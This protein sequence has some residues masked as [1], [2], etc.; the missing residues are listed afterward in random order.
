MGTS[1]SISDVSG[2]PT[3]KVLDEKSKARLQKAVHEFESL[4]VSYMLKSMRATIS[5]EEGFGENFGG[6]MLEGMFDLE[7]SKQMSKNSNL[8]LGEKLYR[9]MTGEALP[10]AT[11]RSPGAAP[12]VEV[13][14]PAA[15]RPVV[16]V[17]APV[18]VPAK[19]NPVVPVPAVVQPRA[20]LPVVPAAAKKDTTVVDQRVRAL[21]PIIQEAAETHDIDPNLLKA[22]IASES[23]GRVRAR[24]SKNAKG[25]MQLIDSTAADMGVHNVWNPREN[26][27]GGA[28]YLQK[29]LD[30]F[31]GDMTKAVASY[32]AGPGAVEKHGGIPP[33]KETQ[34]YVTRVMEFLRHYE[35][36]ESSDNE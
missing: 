7:L 8:G 36:Q 28:K 30:R 29:L 16:A 27:L 34:A 13:A 31:Q 10:V 19:E 1:S 24:S 4:F 20:V 32:N 22:V 3:T 21:E 11:P 26:I 2:Q 6:D 23:G 33:F 14:K 25:V 18:P 15:E 5:K 17:P 12:R 9:E 35:Q